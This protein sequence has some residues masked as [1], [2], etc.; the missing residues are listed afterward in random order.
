MS[1]GGA[2]SDGGTEA[3]AESLPKAEPPADAEKH[4]VGGTRLQTFEAFVQLFDVTRLPSTKAGWYIRVGVTA[5]AVIALVRRVG[6]DVGPML[7][8]RAPAPIA[9]VESDDVKFQ[10]PEGTRRAIFTEIATA[11]LAERQRAIAA[12][13]WNGHV[14]SREDDRGWQERIAVRAAAAKHRISLSQAFLVL[15]EGIRNKWIAPD[16]KP[17]AATT[18]PLNIRSNSW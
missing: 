8:A 6:R 10:I 17:L 18:P 12:N 2:P 7:A 3:D 13:T 16:G 5:L 9:A 4:A 1:T 14:W 11:E 15:D